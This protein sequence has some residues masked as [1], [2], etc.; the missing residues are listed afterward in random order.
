LERY[1]LY[2]YIDNGNIILNPQL[3][4]D[5]IFWR[6]SVHCLGLKPN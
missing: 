2:G 4:I 6:Y 5:F 1:L 3:Q